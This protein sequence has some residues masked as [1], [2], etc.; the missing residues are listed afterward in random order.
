MET[1]LVVTHTQKLPSVD[2]TISKSEKMLFYA[3]VDLENI[4]RVEGTYYDKVNMRN[5]LIRI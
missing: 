5:V 1:R 2:I 4:D 3:G